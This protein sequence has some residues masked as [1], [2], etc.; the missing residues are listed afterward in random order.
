MAVVATPAALQAWEDSRGCDASVTHGRLAPLGQGMCDGVAGWLIKGGGERWNVGGQR[1]SGAAQHVGA[2]VQ[3]SVWRVRRR[4]Q[5]RCSGFLQGELA[6]GTA[7]SVCWYCG[8]QRWAC[9]YSW[10][11]GR[12]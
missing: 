12:R 4:Y 8:A 6:R 10:V 1:G 3:G 7:V 11:S 5:L 2:R 9:M